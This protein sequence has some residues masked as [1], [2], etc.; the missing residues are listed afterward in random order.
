MGYYKDVY[1]LASM[2][3]PFEE[4]L[5]KALRMTSRVILQ[6]PKNI[7]LAQLVDSFVKVAD[8]LRLP[9]KPIEVEQ[10][11]INDQMN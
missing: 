4:I 9:E 6:L 1:D 7:D 2:K 3:P 8:K 5:E 11:L 10:M